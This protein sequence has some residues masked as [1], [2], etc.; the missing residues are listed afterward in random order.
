M[1][2]LYDIQKETEALL[3]AFP[4]T[5]DSDDVLYYRFIHSINPQ[6]TTHDVFMNR[7]RYGLPPY[8]SVR[9]TRQKLQEK[10]PELR[11]SR[12]VREL[13]KER[14]GEFLEYAING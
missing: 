14:E 9:R 6:V 1:K 13:R 2:R 3:E 12:R 5:R 10:R 4:D 7:E 8:E 11:G